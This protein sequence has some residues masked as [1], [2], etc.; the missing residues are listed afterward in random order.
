[1]LSFN[2][3]FRLQF[4]PHSHACPVVGDSGQAGCFAQILVPGQFGGIK[5]EG[6]AFVQVGRPRGS[7]RKARHG[8][9]G[10]EG[11]GRE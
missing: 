9:E 7:W 10:K 2:L 8:S 4:R 3:N 5:T 1:M 6:A 11:A